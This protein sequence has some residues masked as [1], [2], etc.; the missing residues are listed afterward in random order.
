MRFRREEKEGSKGR[1]IS[2]AHEG[3]PLFAPSP[4]SS[5]SI[6]DRASMAA[7]QRGEAGLPAKRYTLLSI[8]QSNSKYRYKHRGNPPYLQWKVARQKIINVM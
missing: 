5:A 3:P 4:C 1:A 7:A 2:A 6:D 8:S